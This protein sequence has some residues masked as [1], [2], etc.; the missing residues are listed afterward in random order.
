MK[1]TRIALAAA[2][3]MAAV[4]P[5]TAQAAGYAI[6]EQGAAVLG[7]AGAGTASVHD[8][9][10]VFFNPAR[11]V[12]LPGTQFYAGGNALTVANSFAGVDPYPGYGVTEA[13]KTQTF[14]PPNV[15]LT[16]NFGGAFAVGAGFNA[17]FGLGIEW[18]NPATFTGR[19]IAT[20]ADVKGLNASLNVAHAIGSR[21]SI[22]VGFDALFASVSLRQVAQVPV[23]GGGGAI[24][25]V[26]TAALK[27]DLTPGYGWNAALW[28]QP[29]PRTQLGLAYRS[30]VS[31]DVDGTVDFT[32]IPTGDPIVDAGAAAKLQDQGVSSTLSFPAQWSMG[33]AYSPT[34]A[35]TFEGDLNWTE[36]SFFKD[37]PI[38]FKKSPALDK[39]VEEDYRDQLQVR[40]GAE[41]RLA[42]YTYRFGYYYDRAAAPVQSVT[43]LLPGRGPQWDLGRLRSADREAVRPRRVRLRVVRAPAQHRR[44]GARQLQ[45]CVQGLRQH[46]RRGAVLPLLAH[47]GEDQR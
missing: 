7:M 12:A 26:A 20:K 27:A 3:L 42:N 40:L 36:W 31:V 1:R 21:A 10:A 4:L 39:K 41:H 45:R 24:V 5:A 15:Y 11:L 37:L 29:T 18:E 22:A 23:P 46:G 6:Y 14:Y 43:P 32:A 33:L 28:L 47:T 30:R 8:A 34:P 44:P 9:S 19:A 25:D 17:P 2:L 35:W 13:M 16:K 38:H